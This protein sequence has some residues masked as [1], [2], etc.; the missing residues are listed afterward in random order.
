MA[1]VKCYWCEQRDEKELMIREDNKKHYHK[2]KCHSSY[3]A[4]K[5]FKKIESEKWSLLYEYVKELHGILI[6]PPRN[7]KRLQDLRNGIDFKDG[8]SYQRY[9]QGV[10]YELM[11]DAYKLSEDKIKWF[12]KDVL[13]GSKDAADINKCITMM[14]NNLN[15]A[16]AKEQHRKKQKESS[17]V[18]KPDDLKIDDSIVYKRKEVSLND[19]TDFL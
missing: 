18:N 12:I 6:V 9:K 2:E 7:I 8:K 5:E 4:D 13:N 14:L 11:L 10:S 3:I 16:W 1:Q 19:I 17:I 15:V